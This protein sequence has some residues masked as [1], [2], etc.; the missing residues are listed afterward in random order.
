MFIP[1]TNLTQLYFQAFSS[2]WVASDKSILNTLRALPRLEI[3]SLEICG[4]SPVWPD[5]IPKE[6]EGVNPIV[7]LNLTSLRISLQSRTCKHEGQRNW[8]TFN[9]TTAAALSKLSF[10]QLKH[11]V[12]VTDTIY[13]Y[14]QDDVLHLFLRRSDVS[15]QTLQCFLSTLPTKP[16]F[17]EI[18]D[19][20]CMISLSRIRLELPRRGTSSSSSSLPVNR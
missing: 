20:T 15:L 5:T 12:Y 8:Q 9:S 1:L 3:L 14:E 7:L 16:T 4:C 13:P 17:Q 18:F 6:L 10:P 2:D 19:A 11:F